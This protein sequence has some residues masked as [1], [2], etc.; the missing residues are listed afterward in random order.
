MTAKYIIRLDDACPTMDRKK[1]DRI[2]QILDRYNIKPIVA[3]IPNNEDV[4]QQRDK[5]DNL[6]WDKVRRWKKKGWNIAMH[7]YNHVYI[8]HNKGMIP[9][10]DKSEFAG[11]PL[12]KQNLK[13]KQAIEIFRKQGI[14]PDIFVAP[15]NTMDTNTLNAI[16]KYTAINII[17]NGVALYPYIKY[18]FI[19]LPVQFTH[20]I[21]HINL[22]VWTVVLHPNSMQ[23]KDIEEIEHDIQIVKN[24]ICTVSDL[25]APVRNKKMCDK[26][27]A[28]MYLDVLEYIC[29]A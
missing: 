12:E 23:N 15:S 13:I 3:V 6:F 22:G 27:F 11:L 10:S 21:K 16:K 28:S 26:I 5:P 20:T 25:K 19:W 7:G 1:W 8:S 4:K 24:K 2:E 17:S 14:E 9:L 29:V 18:G